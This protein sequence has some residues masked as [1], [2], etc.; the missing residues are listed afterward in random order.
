MIREGPSAEPEIREVRIA[1]ILSAMSYALDLTEGAAP[2]HTLRSCVIGMRIGA[3]L[4][5]PQDD[6]A[7]LFYALLLKDAGCSSNAA[8]MCAL[9]GSDD[10][11]VKNS[12]KVL[13]QNDPLNFIRATVQHA[14]IGRPLH[15]QVGQLFTMGVAALQGQQKQIFQIRCERGA[16]IAR[17]MGFTAATAETIRSLDEHWNGKGNPEGLKGEEI[18]LLSRIANISQTLEVFHRSESLAGVARV[19][20][21]RSGTWFDPDLAALVTKWL[22]EPEWWATLESHE[23]EQSVQ[24]LRPDGGREVVEGGT[25]DTVAQAFADIIDAKTPFTF[26]HST[27]VAD[28]AAAIAKT[29]GESATSQRRIRRAG[30]LHDVGKLGISNRILDKS[31]PLTDEERLTVESHPKFTW[32]ILNRVAAFRDFAWMASIHHEKM[33]GSGY[34][35]RLRG[36]Q[37]DEPARMLVV[38]DIYEALTADRPYRAGMTPDKAIGIL[39]SECGAKLWTPAVDALAEVVIR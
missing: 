39:R 25:I 8:K 21:E 6:H 13:D 7:A 38:A 20:K 31:G 4:R 35:F 33:D 2:G 17:R 14:A 26:R 9:F 5:L 23:L 10:R 3:E 11:F 30:L 1:D 28:F 15:V 34:P 22:S 27:K 12:L 32:E 16:D 37:L 36:A 19:L 24:A 29:M 18:P